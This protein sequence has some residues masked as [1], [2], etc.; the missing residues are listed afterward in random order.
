[1]A[2]LLLFGSWIFVEEESPE[3]GILLAVVKFLQGKLLPE[4]ESI[5]IL[6]LMFLLLI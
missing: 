3:V 5:K 2:I 1:M 6:A 4:L